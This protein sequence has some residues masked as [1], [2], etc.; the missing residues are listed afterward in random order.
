MPVVADY[1]VISDAKV[2]L[3]FTGSNAKKFNFSLP[4]LD[5]SSSAVLSFVCIATGNT[6]DLGNLAFEMALNGQDVVAYG[7]RS[8]E[9]STL[10]EVV[11]GSLLQASTNELFVKVISGDGPLEIGDVVLWYKRTI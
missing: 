8:F 11:R 9:V 2:K 1:K 4:G 10:H 7:F 5:K 3:K 6:G